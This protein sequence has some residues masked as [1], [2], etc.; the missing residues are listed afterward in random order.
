M[1]GYKNNTLFL[2]WIDYVGCNRRGPTIWCRHYVLSM[3]D[4]CSLCTRSKAT[5]PVQDNVDTLEILSKNIQGTVSHFFYIFLFYLFKLFTTK[6]SSCLNA[7]MGRQSIVTCLTSINTLVAV[8]EQLKL[9]WQLYIFIDSCQLYYTWNDD[10]ITGV[11]F[12]IHRKESRLSIKIQWC[13]GFEKC[14][15]W[16][17]KL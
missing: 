4:M 15:I 2:S 5:L 12:Q 16:Q 7:S 1:R 11:L 9:I 3:D 14:V 8:E 10:H 6:C 17:I 13:A